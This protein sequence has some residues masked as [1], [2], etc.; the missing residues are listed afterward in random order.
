MLIQLMH[1]TSEDINAF[2]IIC[3][4]CILKYMGNGMANCWV[5]SERTKLRWKEG[6]IYTLESFSPC[7]D[8]NRTCPSITKRTEKVLEHGLIY[9]KYGAPQL[10]SGLAHHCTKQLALSSSGGGGEGGKACLKLRA[11]RPKSDITVS[12]SMN[13]MPQ[14]NT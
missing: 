12:M 3:Q 6:R 7:S 11:N 2:S 5:S 10:H 4:Q 8:N 1:I 13:E 9:P 14:N